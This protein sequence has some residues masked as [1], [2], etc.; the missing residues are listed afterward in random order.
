MVAAV[1][2]Q[3]EKGQPLVEEE[4]GYAAAYA[5]VRYAVDAVYAG[6]EASARAQ[7]YLE[8]G[9]IEGIEIQETDEGW[10]ITGS[11]LAE[12]ALNLG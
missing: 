5:A 3:V 9:E 12:A 11:A 2:E 8:H 1:G 7:A 4:G 10:R 6:S